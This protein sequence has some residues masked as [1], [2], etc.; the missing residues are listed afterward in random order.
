LT[1]SR[2]TPSASHCRAWSPPPFFFARRLDPAPELPGPPKQPHLRA[3]SS[4]PT[5]LPQK[6]LQALPKHSPSRVAPSGYPKTIFKT[7]FLAGSSPPARQHCHYPT[8]SSKGPRRRHTRSRQCR[9]SRGRVPLTR[10]TSTHGCCAGEA[11]PA[12]RIADSLAYALTHPLLS[13]RGRKR[14]A[15]GTG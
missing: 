4:L 3:S 15:T 6:E 14:R 1:R 12:S 7:S 10:A 8:P 2:P 9:S 11:G 5:S 13:G